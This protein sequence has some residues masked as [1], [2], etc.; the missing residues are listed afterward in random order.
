[1][2]YACGGTPGQ[3]IREMDFH[4][5]KRIF[6]CVWNPDESKNL[7]ASCGEDGSWFAPRGATSI[8]AHVRRM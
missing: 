2:S 1:M 6:R 3:V 8:H 7:L 5:Q 4:S